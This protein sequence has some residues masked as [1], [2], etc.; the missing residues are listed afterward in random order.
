M[1]PAVL[2]L[3]KNKISFTLH[4]YEHSSDETN[5]GDEAVKSLG[6]MRDRSTKRCWFPSTATPGIWPLR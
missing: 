2:L 3:E 4:P 1:T 5:F 6:W